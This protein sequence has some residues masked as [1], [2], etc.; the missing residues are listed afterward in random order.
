[1]GLLRRL[2]PRGLQL[3]PN[4]ASDR[5]VVR[6]RVKTR[7]RM[8][9]GVHDISGGDQAITTGALL[10]FSPS[11]RTALAWRIFASLDRIGD[12]IGRT[13]FG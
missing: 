2:R 12:R 11:G 5:Y 13:G 9:L 10:N 6:I 7:F 1:M 4:P 3:L 8:S